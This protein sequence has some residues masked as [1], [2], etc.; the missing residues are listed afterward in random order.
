MDVDDIAAVAFE[1]PVRKQQLAFVQVQRLQGCQCFA[2][3]EGDVDE[4]IIG[5]LNQLKDYL[6][7]PGVFLKWKS[8]LK[9]LKCR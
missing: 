5:D 8:C 4:F 1:K 6:Q 7:Y 9:K 2:I 3:Y